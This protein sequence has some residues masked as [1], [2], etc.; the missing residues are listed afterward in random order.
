MNLNPAPEIQQPEAGEFIKPQLVIRAPIAD[1]EF[2]YLWSVLRAIPFYKKQG[3]SFVLPDHPVFQRLA[4][5]SPK[6]GDVDEAQLR[7]L[8]KTEVYDEKY[9]TPGLTALENERGIIESVFPRLALFQKKWGFR[10]LPKYEVV[11]TSFGPGGRFDLDSGKIIALTKKDGSFKRRRPHHVVVQEIVEMG[12]EYFV[13]KFKLT[14]AEKERVADYTCSRGLGNILEKYTL[15]IDDPS[16]S[17]VGDLRI[18][19][20]ITED[21]LNDLPLALENYVKDFPRN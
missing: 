12:L 2:E 17:P 5:S 13:K 20:Y 7:K 15:K 4:Q 9:Y 18:D 8:F 16:L 1:E 19:P 21:A 11:L 3:Y 10:L 14:H 6:F